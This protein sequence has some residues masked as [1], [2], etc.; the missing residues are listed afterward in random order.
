METLPNTTLYEKVVENSSSTIQAVNYRI[1]DNIVHINVDKSTRDLHQNKS[2]TF[3]TTRRLY[4]A[5]SDQSLKLSSPSVVSSDSSV[6]FSQ[7]SPSGTLIAILRKDVGVSINSSDVPKPRYVF[8]ILDAKSGEALFFI[9]IPATVHENVISDGFFGCQLSWSK[10]E[11]YI[12][13]VA[14]LPNETE[15]ATFPMIGK[16]DYSDVEDFGEKYVGTKRPW[17]FILNL[18]TKAV[19]QLPFDASKKPNGVIG[20]P[21]WAPNDEYLLYN[22]Y[23]IQQKKLGFLYCYQRSNQLC[24]VKVN[25]EGS[26]ESHYELTPSGHNAA[27]FARF[28]PNG[29]YF[30]YLSPNDVSLETHNGSSELRV[31][32]WADWVES[33]KIHDVVVVKSGILYTH[34]L[35]VTCWT[36][37][38]NSL[39]LSSLH[40]GK[41][42]IYRVDFDF[43]A[44]SCTLTLLSFH[45][46]D[47]YFTN[48]LWGTVTLGED[49]D[50]VLLISSSAPNT[51]EQFFV[52]KKG[53]C[54]EYN[55]VTSEF[56]S[57]S[58]SNPFVA[59]KESF[60]S[61]LHNLVKWTK[62]SDFKTPSNPNTF[63]AFLLY[64]NSQSE[65][66][67]LISVPHGG[68]HMSFNGEFLH[69]YAFLALQGF[70]VLLI[71]F[72]GSTGYGDSFH[73]ALLGNIGTYDV[74]DV[75]NATLA[76]VSFKKQAV[77]SRLLELSKRVNF[78]L[79][80]IQCPLSKSSFPD[81]SSSKIG[82]IGGS[83][84]GFLTS[85]L[86]GQ[87]PD[88]FAGACMRN[89][90]TNIP[91]MLTTSD[92]S[93]WCIVEA[94]G[95]GYFPFEKGAYLPSQEEILKMHTSSPIFHIK[96]VVTP[97][98]LVLG[99][100]DRRVPP[101]QGI[102]YFQALKG[103]L[104]AGKARCLVYPEDTHPI[105]KPASEAD[106]WIHMSNWM[107]QY[108]I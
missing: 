98:L 6:V 43:V 89:P 35:P 46:P 59:E 16:N 34:S 62:I 97:T 17:V 13:Y 66:I 26:F 31:F 28:S 74:H 105:D 40:F 21:L 100:K 68:P 78:K 4:R 108:L 90:V 69:S 88:L 10:N 29:K 55:I 27:R 24:A 51:S 71:N 3:T 79:D 64:P 47:M 1:I 39:F 72:R 81:L 58:S 37:S 42:C 38:S 67:P 99:L 23:P 44:E 104:P 86:I 22:Y 7:V 5:D 76:A 14:E 106:A 52:V 107:K 54:D 61:S 15:S 73:E 101:S 32:F 91:S 50:P 103:I 36:N 11:K 96:N 60:Q 82:V 80:E 102:E 9:Q 41:Q 95:R 63:D 8:D 33:K 57:A 65:D 53:D 92:I 19:T 56:V 70:A 94:I 85:H 30:V 48:V 83:H 45:L 49:E 93:D 2:R 20:Q 77:P 18:S 75:V 87:F 25:N 84:G 12:A